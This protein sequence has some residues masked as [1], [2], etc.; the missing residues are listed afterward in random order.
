MCPCGSGKKYKRCCLNHDGQARSGLTLAN[1]IDAI[2]F[3]LRHQGMQVTAI[4]LVNNDTFLVEF[5]AEHT[6]S[7]DIKSELA[8]AIAFL[9]GYFRDNDL[10]TVSVKNYAAQAFATDGKPLIHA[11]SS[12]TAAEH[13]SNGRSIEWLQGTM[14]QE[15][16]QEFRLGLAK[17]RIAELEN[18]LRSLI[19]SVLNAAVGRDWWMQ[20]V[21][22]KVRQQTETMYERQEGIE[23]SNGD[24]LVDFTFLLDLRRIIVSNWNR[25]SHVFPDQTRFSDRLELLN[26]IRRREAHNRELS[27]QDVEDLDAIYSELMISIAQVI[28]GATSRF[29][30]E[31]WRNRL[32]E[33]FEAATEAQV[34]YESDGSITS[35]IQAV[36][37]Q[38]GRFEDIETQVSSLV[39]PPP[40]QSIHD[41][42]LKH[43]SGVRTA[44]MEMIEVDSIR[45]AARLSDAQ[46][47]FESANSELLAFREKYLM[48]VL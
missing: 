21:G 38:I 8:T 43:L 19:R 28:P 42:L 44:M 7:I 30:L 6:S 14:F 4:R 36:C 37:Q 11:I 3:G 31:N 26:Q 24:T 20:C 45:D 46:L 39:P 25:F 34:V 35:G 18:G 29:L 22:N 1:T 47:R 41:E 10:V 5:V 13:L 12:V 40:M 33:I 15:H 9:N 16:T 23:C 17:R 48:T 32:S 27:D 2:T